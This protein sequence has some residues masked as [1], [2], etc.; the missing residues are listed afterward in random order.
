MSV[1]E[2]VG[3]RDAVDGSL[4]AAV[5]AA[6][7][8]W[9]AGLRRLVVLVRE[10]EVSGEWAA[11]GSPS[12]AHW[13][14]DALDLELST[15]REWLRV[16][17]SLLTFPAI[18]EAF[19]AGRLSYSKVRA[20]TRV[21]TVANQAELCELAERVPARRMAEEVAKWLAHHETPAETKARHHSARSFSSHL[22][23][24]G[25][26][27]G[28]FR[29]P[30]ADAKKLTAPVDELV[31]RRRPGAR[32]A[33]DASADACS[34]DGRMRWPTI[35]QQRADA[36]MEIVTGG[37]GEL[38]TEIVVHVRGDGCSLDDGTPIAGSLVE[39]IAPEAFLR[40]LIHDAERRPI[41]ASGRQRHPTARQRRVV[42]ERDRACV[43]CGAT[44]FLQYDHDPD[45]EQSRHTVV[46]E[47]WLRCWDCHR[48]R[49]RK[50]QEALRS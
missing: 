23:I 26:V 34:P 13:I 43:D 50:L 44:E 28:S 32:A 42:R 37:G 33:N 40:V 5:L 31:L 6:G 3:R 20:L 48:N 35:A 9:S 11:D 29:L 19:T 12:C 14:A 16:G 17:W 36:F 22:A 15:A 47:L 45:F 4:R 30:P 2:E 27:V 18:G 39:R 21:A 49:H 41:N 10:L 8:Q 7:Q 38:L 25:M 46:E 1:I 24:D